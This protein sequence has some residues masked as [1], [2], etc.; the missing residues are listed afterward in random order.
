MNLKITL[1]QEEARDIHRG[2]RL[3][4]NLAVIRHCFGVKET[5][6]LSLCPSV[7]SDAVIVSNG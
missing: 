2:F 6:S 5:L 4:V 7:R 1:Q 3:S